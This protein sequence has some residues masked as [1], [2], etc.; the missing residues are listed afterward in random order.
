MYGLLVRLVF[1]AKVKL[2]FWV[3]LA[4]GVVYMLYVHMCVILPYFFI[5]VVATVPCT[6]FFKLLFSFSLCFFIVARVNK[7]PP[8]HLEVTVFPEPM[9]PLVP[10]VPQG[11]MAGREAR[12]TREPPDHLDL[13]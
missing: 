4:Y 3:K 6:S 13:P 12:V 7:V 11:V 10:L 5:F 2:S 1:Y 9:V 8:V